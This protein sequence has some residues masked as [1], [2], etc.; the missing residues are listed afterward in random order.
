MRF[1]NINVHF[2]PHSYGG[3]TV[4]AERLAHGLIELGHE[5]INVALGQRQAADDFDCR[6][7]P[8]GTVLLLNNIERSRRTWF[9]NAPASSLIRDLCQLVQ[10]DR[11]VLHAPQHLGIAELASDAGF[12]SR[13][14]VVAHDSFWVCMEGTRM[15][16]SGRRCTRSP[17]PSACHDCAYYPGLIEA[18]YATLGHCLDAAR[19]VI[20]PSHFLLA[21]YAAALHGAPRHAVVVGNPDLAEELVAGEELPP[22]D[23][24][25]VAYFGGPGAAKGWDV[26]RAQVARLRD[27]E[28]RPIEYL[29]FDAGAMLGQ[30]WYGHLRLP[31]HAKVQPAFHWSQSRRLLAGIDVAVVPSRVPE[32]FGLA[33]REILSTGGASVVFPTGALAELEGYDRVSVADEES[34]DDAVRAAARGRLRRDKVYPHRSSLDYAREIAGAA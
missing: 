10:P 32:S 18:L 30:S 11:I 19:R 6:D 15:L 23:A 4:V 13:T 1:L 27:V 16:P 25:R 21:Q 3:A 29:L 8:F 24:L 26:V 31:S 28:D 7:T 14:T 17:S 33:A 5:V 2:F 22:S 9:H 34:I 20:F 12:W